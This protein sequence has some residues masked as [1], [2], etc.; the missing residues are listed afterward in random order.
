MPVR[1]LSFLV[2]ALLGCSGVFWALQLLA[3]PLPLPAHAAPAGDSALPRGDLSRLLGST[4]VG[5][6]SEPAPV[7]GESRFRLLGV[8][9]PKGGDVG[10]HR[11]EGVAL[12]A[13]DGAPARPVRVGAAVD[14]ELRLLALDARSASLG[15]G[16][17]TTMTLRLEAPAAAAT[18]TPSVA[19]PTPTAAGLTAPEAPAP[20]LEVTPPPPR[21]DG[22]VPP[23]S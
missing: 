1:L 17:V 22:R 11:G 20:P 8:V 9:S 2:W 21:A 14:G 13:I 4:P 16:G 10:A 7:A 3:R 6:P 15:Q 18:G 19:V 5:A 23:V 12:I